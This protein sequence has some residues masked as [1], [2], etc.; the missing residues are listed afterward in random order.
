MT[1]HII[2]IETYYFH[3]H[4]VRTVGYTGY[5][6]LRRCPT[7]SVNLAQWHLMSHF[8]HFYQLLVPGHNN[9]LNVLHAYTFQG[10][11]STL[12]SVELVGC[13]HFPS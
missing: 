9:S 5:L 4:Q 10:P 3:I 2:Q 13:L 12:T 1:Y 6:I 7:S 8:C 11:Q